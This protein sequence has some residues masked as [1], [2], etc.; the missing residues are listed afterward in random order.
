MDE[1]SEVEI[2]KR[3]KLLELCVQSGGLFF[4]VTEPL[5]DDETMNI[6]PSTM[7]IGIRGTCGWVTQNPAALLEGTVEVTAGEQ[8]VTISSGCPP[9]SRCKGSGPLWE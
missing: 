6:A 1:D 9:C 3:D 7:I 8:S 4:N 5:T 2:V